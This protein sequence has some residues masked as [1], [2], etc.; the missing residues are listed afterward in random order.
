M[1]LRDLIELSTVMLALILIWAGSSKALGGRHRLQASIEGYAILPKLLVVP[2]AVTLPWIEM[3]LG[4]GLL[5]SFAP[6]IP[7][8]GSGVILLGFT[9][10]MVTSLVQGR[11]GV[12]CGC[13]GVGS[14]HSVSWLSVGQ[15]LLLL[16]L[17]AMAAIPAQSNGLQLPSP[18][19][20]MTATAD[21]TVAI[22]ARIVFRLWR[23]V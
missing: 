4:I 5:T 6:P 9:V 3:A 13:F 15:N 20:F 18:P 8:L 2:V 23:V 22:L 11:R 17:A 14:G 12:D 21:L 16:G 19:I 7:A 1:R 10:G